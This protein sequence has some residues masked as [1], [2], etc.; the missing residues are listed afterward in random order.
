MPFNIYDFGCWAR[1]T[2]V[3]LTV[4]A[5]YRPVRPIPFGI[6]ELRT[7]DRPPRAEPS[8][9]GLERPLHA[10]RPVA[11]PLRAPRPAPRRPLDGAR[12][13]A[14]RGGAL[15]RAPPGGRRQ[16]GRDPAAVGLLDPGAAPARLRRS[17]TRCSPRRFEGLE[18][19]IDPPG[20]PCAGSRRASRR[21]GTRRS[22][23][24]ALADAGVPPERPALRTRRGLAGRRGD[25]RAGRLGGAP[26]RAHAGR[27]GLRVRQRQLPRRRR[28]R[29]G[30][31][32][33][34]P[35]R[36]E[37]SRGSSR[38]PSQRAR[39]AGPRA[40]RR[41]TARGA[42]STPTTSAS[43][44]TS[45]PS[46]TS[47][48]SST[49]RARTSPPTSSRCSPSEP[50]GRPER[51]SARA[52]SWLRDEQEDDGAWFGRW[53]VNYVYG[54]GAAVPA[55]VAAGVTP[56]DPAIRR[57]VGF[58]EAHQNDDGGWGEDIRS[59]D[60]PALAGLGRLD[61]LA[62]GL[63]AARARRL[64][65]RPAAPRRGAGSPGSPR[66]S[67]RTGAG[68]SRG[69]PGPASPGTSTSTT[70]STGSSSPSRRSVAGAGRSRPCHRSRRPARAGGPGAPGS[71]TS[72]AGGIGMTPATAVQPLFLAPLRI[73]LLALRRG[74]PGVEIRRIGMGPRAATAARASARGH[75]GRRAASRP[76]S[77][78]AARSPTTCARATSSSPARSAP[79]ARTTRSC[80]PTPARSAKLLELAAPASRCRHAP[81]VSLVAGRCA[82]TRPGRRLR[83]AARSPSRWSRCGARRSRAGT[84]SSSCAPSS[85]CRVESSSQ[86]NPGAA[87]LPSVRSPAP[88]APSRTGSPLP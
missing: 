49:R 34:A 72:D 64:P 62:D 47:A 53:G 83:P 35:R 30:R 7:G 68:T 88:H 13:C 69:T 18:G 40:W 12:G 59:Y 82:A 81:V 87:W 61:G 26:A 80:F 19:F 44:S 46:A 77:A 16:L 15:D 50:I 45:C 22:P 2:V 23:S 8:L 17:T 79:S 51:W 5:A 3:A 28:H 56:D 75:V 76:R 11:A 27:L 86:P 14:R 4:V 29:R 70:T 60:D 71:R 9:Q 84:R 85:T 10:A 25:P 66:P 43:S 21:S 41:R 73:E 78:S 65:A 58:L 42:R 55:L 6:E 24:I 74:A 52:S 39:R 36:S 32:G 33:P 1:Q 37:R 67:A 20:R 57:A 48:R 38:P 54:V 63:G 31:A